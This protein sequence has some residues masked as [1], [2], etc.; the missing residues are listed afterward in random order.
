MHVLLKRMKGLE[1][2]NLLI[3]IAVALVCGKMMFCFGVIKGPQ[4]CIY[5]VYFN[6][7]ATSVLFLCFTYRKPK[8]INIIVILCGAFYENQFY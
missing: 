5:H 8:L 2:E 4:I 3:L 6:F 1:L 7:L